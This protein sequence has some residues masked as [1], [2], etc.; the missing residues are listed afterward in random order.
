MNDNSTQRPELKL[1]VKNGNDIVNE[2]V[3]GTGNEDIYTINY[4]NTTMM[5]K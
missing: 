5:V 4:Q 3:T 2:K 1:V